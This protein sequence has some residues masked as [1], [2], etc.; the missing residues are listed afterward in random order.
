M[1]RKRALLKAVIA[2]GSALAPVARSVQAVPGAQAVS[3]ADYMLNMINLER[4]KVAAPP[5]TLGNNVAAQRHAENMV[6]F[7]F[8]GHWGVD[9]TLPYMRY[10]L[11]GGCQ[12]NVENTMGREACHLSSIKEDTS[13]LGHPMMLMYYGLQALMDSPGH[14]K[15][16]LAPR[17]RKVNIGIAWDRYNFKLVQ[18]FE[19]GYV[20]MPTM[21]YIDKTG[22]LHLKGFLNHTSEIED[23]IHAF[24]VSYDPPPKM[25]TLG[26]LARVASYGQPKAK[27]ILLQSRPTN[28]TTEWVRQFCRDPYLVSDELLPP[29]TIA[30][31][32]TLGEEA[33]TATCTAD[34]YPVKV[35]MANRWNY[36][37]GQSP[38]KIEAVITDIL[39]ENGPGV[40]T[41]SMVTAP[42]TQT[43][44][45]YSIFHDVEAPEGYKA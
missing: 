23:V 27:L 26:Q 8:S 15:A 17:F 35:R 24:V 22:R 20:R 13:E 43:V 19:T 45:E 42:N 25:L 16:V 33:R 40:Y 39:E 36:I 11:A 9:G 38:F 37:I 7:C 12:H 28:E 5:L 41:V 21:P 29:Q 44:W 1:L 31:S 18:Q 32:A 6:R 34:R 10:S 3:Y 2:G 4:R 14:R 30:E